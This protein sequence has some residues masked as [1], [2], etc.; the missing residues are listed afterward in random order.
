MDTKRND[1]VNIFPYLEKLYEAK[2]RTHK[3]EVIILSDNNALSF[4]LK[5]GDKVFPGVPVVFCGINNFNDAM[6]AGHPEITGIV[7]DYDLKGTIELILRL[8]PKVKQ[9]ACITDIVPTGK[10]HRQR[11]NKVAS[12][13]NTKVKFIDL[14][15][16]TAAQLREALS[17]LPDDSVLIELSYFRDRTGAVF[18]V[19]EATSFIAERGLP[20][21][22]CWE[23]FLGIGI[24]GGVMTNGQSHGKY[25]A[26]MAMKILNG[27]QADTIPVLRKSP[28]VPMFDY[29]QMKRFDIKP[30]DLPKNSVIINKPSSF[31]EENKALIC[32]IA[33][34]IIIQTSIIL[35]LV[36]NIARRRRVEQELKLINKDRE[37]IFQALGNGVII[38]D[39]EFNIMD[40]NRSIVEATGIQK[41]E[42]L[43]KKCYTIFHETT[44]P[45]ENCPAQQIITSKKWVPVEREMEALGGTFLVSCTPVLDEDEHLVKIIHTTTDLTEHKLLEEQ[46]RHSQKMEAIGVL[47]GGIAHDFNNI[48]TAIQGYSELALMTVQEDSTLHQYLNEIRKA[49]KRAADL[50]SQMLFFSRKQPITMVPLDLNQIIQNLTRMIG[51]IIGEDIRLHTELESDLWPFQGDSGTIEQVIMNLVVN[52]RDAMPTGGDITIQTQNIQVDK[53]YCNNYRYARPGRFV[54]LRVEDTGVGIDQEIIDRI[55]EPFFT[56]KGVGKGTGMGLSVVYGIVKQHEGW[57]NVESPPDQGTVCSIYLPAVF[58]K[59]VKEQKSADSLHAYRGKGER[60]LLVEDEES[61]RNLSTMMLSETGYVVFHA[62][63]AKE[64][65]DIFKKER[66]NF[67]LILSDVVLPGDSGLMLVEQLRKLKPGINVLFTS[68]YSDEKSGRRLIQERKY[69]YLQKPYELVVLLQTIRDALRPNKDRTDALEENP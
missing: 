44:K 67:D 30:S 18:T 37:E 19:K 17:R 6:I 68:G 38:I 66:G 62:S 32:Y 5:N 14:A 22:S 40:A 24:L 43:G 3:T 15:E 54:C 52:A 12:E 61:V 50:T 20:I 1:P 4:I 36:I 41:S 26:Q 35:I 7:E 49:S 65:L 31:Y 9:I 46:L 56:T 42:L 23:I 58:V 45:P 29:A 51:R 33:A 27:A 64:A 63:N 57:V 8:H 28:N 2:Y 69:P 59:P 25:A 53:E 39:P 60:I 48:L 21:Y 47:A 16:L 11:F 34:F 55:F 13:I 10:L